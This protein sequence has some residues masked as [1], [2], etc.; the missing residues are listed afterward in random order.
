MPVNRPLE[1]A[2]FNSGRLAFR[3]S[4]VLGLWV[5]AHDHAPFNLVAEERGDSLGNDLPTREH[6]RLVNPVIARSANAPVR[7]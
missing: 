6:K 2:K 5:V 4:G 7:L 1:L 3:A